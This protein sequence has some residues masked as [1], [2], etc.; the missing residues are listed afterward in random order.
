[1]QQFQYH[2]KEKSSEVVCNVKSQMTNYVHAK[3]MKLGVERDY[4][5][6]QIYKR[7]HKEKN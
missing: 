1:M 4:K 5:S 6:P 3:H 7:V 2:K